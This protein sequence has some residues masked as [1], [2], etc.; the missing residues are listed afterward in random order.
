MK[1]ILALAMVVGFA[2]ASTLAATQQRP[3]EKGDQQNSPSS[4]AKSLRGTIARVDNDAKSLTVKDDAGKEMTVFWNES[5]KIDGGELKEGNAVS[6]ETTQ[7]DGKTLATSIKVTAAK[8]P[9]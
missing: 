8:K 3:R 1:K 6:L 4:Q 9:Y 7:Q 2:A 5:T